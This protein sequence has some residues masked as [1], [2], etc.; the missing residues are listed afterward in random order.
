MA[1]VPV[2]S[3]VASSSLVVP[4]IFNQGLKSNLGP[5]IFFAADA[6]GVRR[7]RNR[8]FEA[9]QQELRLAQKT[10]SAF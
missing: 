2:T 4:A 3:E 5:L 10:V 8:A 6:S 9:R 1:L 7:N